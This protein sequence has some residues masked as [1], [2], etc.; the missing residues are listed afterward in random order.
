MPESHTRRVL[1]RSARRP[2]FI[3]IGV[4]TALFAGCGVA[5]KL[6]DSSTACADAS[7]SPPAVVEQQPVHRV[8]AST[9][10]VD[11]LQA[12]FKQAIARAEPSV[13]SIYSTKKVKISRAPGFGPFGGHPLERFF[14]APGRSPREFQQ[15]GLGSGF[16]V[17]RDGHII[18]N[19]HVVADADEIKIRLSDGRELDATVVGTDP[20]TDLAVLKVEGDHDLPSIELGD[21]SALE[22]GDWVLA[23]GNPFGLPRTVSAGIVSAVGRANMG[24]VDY[25]D[26]IQ[27]DAAVNPGNSGGPLVDL[28]GR[29]VG[30][31][32]AIASRS[33]GNQGIAFAIPVDMAK[34]IVDQLRDGGKVT[35]G[36]L[37]IVISDLDADMAATFAYE[38]DDGI[39]V[40][41]VQQDSPAAK[42]GLREGDIIVKL[43]GTKVDEV[44]RFR[45]E[46]ARRAPGSTT[47]LDVWRD[48]RLQAL[49]VDLGELPGG[50]TVASKADASTKLGIGL[51]DVT[52]EL[53]KRLQLGDAQG[54]VVAEVEPGSPAARAGLRPGDLLEEVGNEVVRSAGR[55]T[56]LLAKTDLSAGVRLRIRRDGTGLFL[57]IKA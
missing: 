10:A 48:G 40:Q 33:G 53:R 42:A 6:T 25:E 35:R 55:A 11:D 20:P 15:Q 12:A 34:T 27:T 22:V 23:I 19:N 32:T 29:V 31:N 14:D 46:I 54:V 2:T 16:I 56:E 30:I 51:R 7:T 44:S 52:P 17:D 43:D 57:F 50:P 36:H 39:L 26:F 3:S 9:A 47:R 24:I 45:T 49:R 8:V 21:S 5:S 38:G 1:L 13:V 37:G 4:V 28:A 41:N 18:T